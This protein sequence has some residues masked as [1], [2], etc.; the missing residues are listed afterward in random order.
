MFIATFFTIAKIWK[1]MSVDK[2]M[3]EENGVYIYTKEYY[4]VIKKTKIVHFETS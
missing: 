3:D 1:Q 4:S 2:L